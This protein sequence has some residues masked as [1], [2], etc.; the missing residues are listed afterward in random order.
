MHITSLYKLCHNDYYLF[1]ELSMKLSVLVITTFLTCTLNITNAMDEANIL[2]SNAT[3]DQPYML[4]WNKH[5]GNLIDSLAKTDSKLGAEVKS[6]QTKCNNILKNTMLPTNL[7]QDIYDK[8]HE[9]LKDLSIKILIEFGLPLGAQPHS[10]LIGSIQTIC[11][12]ITT[13]IVT[14][15]MNMIV[16]YPLF[17]QGAQLNFD[18]SKDFHQGVFQ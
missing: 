9:E 3:L 7:L 1:K 17:P 16:N 6:F 13:H 8:Y 2:H 15:K 18:Y 4:R 10:N 11:S 14:G 12:A 5:C